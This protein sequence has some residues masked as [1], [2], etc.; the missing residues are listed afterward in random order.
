MLSP[1]VGSANQMRVLSVKQ[2]WADLIASGAKSIE[3][4]SWTTSYR[5]PVLIAACA[6]PSRT[7]D[8]R[9]HEMPP[10]DRLGILVCIVQLVDVRPATRADT[11]ACGGFDP[12][13]E[14]AWVLEAPRRVHPVKYRG[15]LGLRVISAD[16]ARIIAASRA[17]GCAV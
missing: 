7:L 9:R 1:A 2:P 8:A 16:T 14:Y 12:S 11:H 3:V 4:R 13:G 15:G 17:L 5:G 10:P 6:Q